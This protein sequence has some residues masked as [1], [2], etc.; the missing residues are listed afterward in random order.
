MRKGRDILRRLHLHMAIFMQ[1][2]EYVVWIQNQR[3]VYT[4]ERGYR[5]PTGPETKKRNR[6]FRKKHT[7]R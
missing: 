4:S 7:M 1:Y 6:G 3:G 2:R 5:K